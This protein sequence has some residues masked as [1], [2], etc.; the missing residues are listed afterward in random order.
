VYELTGRNRTALYS[1][2]FEVFG[3]M[4]EALG[5]ASPGWLAGDALVVGDTSDGCPGDGRPG[6]AEAT[7]APG[8][9]PA[10]PSGCCDTP[11]FEGPYGYTCDEWISPGGPDYLMPAGVSECTA[12]SGLVISDCS[13]CPP[14]SNATLARGTVAQHQLGYGHFTFPC[15]D[16]FGV[17]CEVG[18]L[19]SGGYWSRAEVAAVRAGCR[20]TCGECPPPPPPAG[21]DTPGNGG[22]PRPR[23]TGTNAS[24]GKARGS[25]SA[26]AARA[27]AGAPVTTEPGAADTKRD[28]RAHVSTVIYTAAGLA[29]AMCA[30]YTVKQACCEKRGDLRRGQVGVADGS[31]YAAAQP[32][33]A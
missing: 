26:A 2:R 23:A 17:A 3:T 29:A 30:G 4:R 27:A 15:A 6:A 5:S 12:S 7:P 33:V 11:G 14:G 13:D 10:C 9:A 32:D 20:R 1:H 8:P 24:A 21:S 28:G 22:S 19:Y 25:S 16:E 31:I 18:A